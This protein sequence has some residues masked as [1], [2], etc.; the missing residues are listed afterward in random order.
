MGLLGILRN[1]HPARVTATV[2]APVRSR[3]LPLFRQSGI[4]CRRLPKERS[5][6]Y[7]ERLIR[8]EKIQM[9]Q[10][11]HPGGE[12]ARSAF[13]SNVPHV[14]YLAGLPEAIYSAPSKTDL[15]TLLFLVDHLSKAVVVSCK[16]LYR[17]LPKPLQRKAHVIPNSGADPSLF[18]G[19]HPSSRSTRAPRIGMVGNFYP[20]KRH[21]DFLKASLRIRKRIPSAKFVIAGRVVGRE[22]EQRRQSISYRR[23]ILQAIHRLDL[24]HCVR[25]T[26]Y[27]P[28]ERFSWLSRLDLLL[29]PSFEGLGQTMLEAGLC[30][31]P[32]V[33]ANAGGAREIIQQEQTGRLVPYGNPSAMAKAAVKLLRDPLL[34]KWLG[35][36]GRKRILRQ[37]SAARHA[38]RLWRLYVRVLS[39][40]RFSGLPG[41]PD[42]VSS[43]DGLPK[44]L[45]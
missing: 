19:V 28:S 8:R 9:V 3:Y 37:F 26:S 40:P 21:R 43:Q 42:T 15:E 22:I 12:G 10:S 39:R 1:L 20:A 16:D 11:L 31:V 6:E 14:W 25:V 34:S 45:F 18:P 5:V 29:V 44:N 41:D 35:N 7:L 30:R 27:R 13:L 17:R 24:G 4:P 36:N 32:I 2:A 38:E 23:L 33:A